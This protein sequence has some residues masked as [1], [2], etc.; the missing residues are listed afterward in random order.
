[1]KELEHKIRTY[2]VERK[3]DTLRPSDLAK[4]IAIEAGELLEIFQW[5]NPSLAE[6]K[7]NPVK[8][9]ELKK[10][11][12]DVLIYCLDIAVLLEFDTEEII[13]EKL[14][15]IEKKYPAEL[16]QNRSDEHEPGAGADETYWKIKKEYRQK[17]D[18]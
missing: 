9:A 16:F 10:E 15:H 2:L 14:A 11:L 17:G 4:S 13:L 1:M 6:V 5:E 12:A 18:I 8:L 3:W 7:Q